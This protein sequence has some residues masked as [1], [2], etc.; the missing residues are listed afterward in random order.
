MTFGL[1]VTPRSAGNPGPPG[2]AGAPGSPG[3]N[4]VVGARGQPGEPGPEGAPGDKGARGPIGLAGFVGPTGPS[5][6]PGFEGPAGERGLSGKGCDGLPG[7]PPKVRRVLFLS[8]SGQCLCMRAPCLRCWFSLFASSFFFKQ[9]GHTKMMHST[10]GHLL[11]SSVRMLSENVARLLPLQ[12]DAP[13]LKRLHRG[14]D[15]TCASYA[16]TVAPWQALDA[17]GVCGGD[18]SECANTYAKRTAH[19]I[20]D[21]HYLTLD[22]ISFDY[23]AFPAPRSASY[24]RPFRTHSAASTALSC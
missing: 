13:A 11:K 12:A 2:Q 22:G 15:A 1:S 17:C 14:Q 3:V 19:A 9:T 16:Q 6:P 4:G 20:G 7:S 10:R 23:Q 24:S 18:E 8:V 5:G 21:P